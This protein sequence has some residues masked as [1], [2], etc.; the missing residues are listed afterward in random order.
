M[1]L[2]ITKDNFHFYCRKRI[3]YY[4]LSYFLLKDKTQEEFMAKF[5]S[6]SS[7]QLFVDKNEQN[8][9]T[10]KMD[11]VINYYVKCPKCKEDILL[12]PILICKKHGRIGT[13]EM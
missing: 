8:I 5:Y 1:A 13:Y 3:E 2:Q 6:Q 7:L 9:H 4:L 11:S 12:N 10:N